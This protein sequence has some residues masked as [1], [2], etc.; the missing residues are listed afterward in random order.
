[1]SQFTALR[2]CYQTLRISYP[3]SPSSL[4]CITIAYIFCAA[5]STFRSIGVEVFAGHALSFTGFVAAVF[6]LT[7][8]FFAAFGFPWTVKPFLIFMVIL[9]AVT[10][11][12]MDTLGVIID[13]DMI[14]N[15]MVT[16]MT[17]SKHLLTVGFVSHVVIFGVLPA[18][19]VA[20]VK[21]Q[22]VSTLKTIAMP[23]VTLTLSL[24][25]AAGLLMTD[26]KAY[27]S[28]L[29]ERKAI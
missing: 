9:S 14:Q 20:C 4:T 2:S 5:N 18:A 19:L 1:M 21:I 10:S 6:F 3:I 23:V 26:L 27:S 29:R 24:A 16:T 8:A 11:Y 25:L 13:R 17:E 15:V 28:I 22:R 7:L 12:Y